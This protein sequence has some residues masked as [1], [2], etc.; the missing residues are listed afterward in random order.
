MRD[1]VVL[2]RKNRPATT[3][4]AADLDRG[5]SFSQNWFYE[6]VGTCFP[7]YGLPK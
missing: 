6:D 5:P 2:S 4:I 3:V 7:C 1:G